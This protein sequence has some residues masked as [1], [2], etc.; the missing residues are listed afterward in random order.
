MLGKSPCF[1]PD[2]VPHLYAGAQINLWGDKTL[3]AESRSWHSKMTNSYLTQVLVLSRMVK[4]PRLNLERPEAR[5]CNVF[6]QASMSLCTEDASCP[7][8]PCPT[9]LLAATPVLV[10]S[11]SL[12]Y[13]G[14]LP[15]TCLS[16]L[17]CKLCAPPTEI[18]PM[19]E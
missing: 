13:Q 8:H 15:I 1:L 11:S 5:V 14:Y 16:C 7:C 4:Q 18:P 3:M 19:W 12:S 6:V 10:F 2:H 9:P 17:E